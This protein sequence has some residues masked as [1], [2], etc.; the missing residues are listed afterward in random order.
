MGFKDQNIFLEKTL[1][2]QNWYYF[3]VVVETS[4]EASHFFFVS[5]N[6]D[7]NAN[8]VIKPEKTKIIFVH[9]VLE[10]QA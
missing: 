2:K 5:K 9:G 4:W 7:F 3:L 10:Q 6:I 8:F 1:Q